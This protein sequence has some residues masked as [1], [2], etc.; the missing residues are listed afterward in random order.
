MK[1]KALIRLTFLGS[2]VTWLVMVFSDVTVLFSALKGLTPD[3][4]LW[5]PKVMLDLY[6]LCIFYYYKFKI[7]KDESLNFTDLL[8][9]VFATGLVA[10]VIKDP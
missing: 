1:T 3:V 2:V 4:P 9:R 8:W 5:L 7:D 10:T 6:V